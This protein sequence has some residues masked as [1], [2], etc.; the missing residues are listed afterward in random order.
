M[1]RRKKVVEVVLDDSYKIPKVG[2]ITKL[3]GKHV[4]GFSGDTY[5]HSI[6]LA[7]EWMNRTNSDKH[8]TQIVTLVN[9]YPQIMGNKSILVSYNIQAKETL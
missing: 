1:G 6:Q 9:Y 4:Q 8:S 2:A 7:Y 3:S 5:N